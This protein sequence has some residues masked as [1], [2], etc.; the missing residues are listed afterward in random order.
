MRDPRARKLTPFGVSVFTEFTA[1]ARAHDAINL[2]QGY[3]DFDGPDLI[4]QVAADNIWRGHNQYAPSHGMPAL[5]QAIADKAKRFYDLEVDPEE[6]VTVFCGA[7]E[8]IAAS[9]LGVIDPGDEVILFEPCYDSYPPAVAMAGGVA[10]RVSLRFPDYAIDEAALRAAFTPRTKA[11]VVNTP[12]NPCGKVFTRAELQLIADLCCERD[13]FA[14]TDEVYEHLTYDGVEHVPL[15]TLPEMRQRTVCI[16]STAKTFSLTGWKVGYTVAGPAL[17]S[18]VRQS[19]QFLTFCTPPPLQ[20]AMAAA[21]A[22]SDDYYRELLGSYAAKRALLLERL[23][24]MG[25][26]VRS[27]PGTYYIAAGLSPLGVDDDYD[28]CR[29]LPARCGVAMIPVSAFYLDR[30]AGRQVVRIAFCKNEETLVEACARLE[31]A[32][33]GGDR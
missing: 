7:T 27:P 32:L 18:A 19:H 31:L 16:S 24:G 2:S 11:V 13:V 28:F 10:R 12:M 20:E 9:L 14:L 5:R 15:I 21:M 33:Q 8:A 25:F 22:M 6:E 17:S 3:P 26:E 1:L 29:A 30:R 23:G 4:K